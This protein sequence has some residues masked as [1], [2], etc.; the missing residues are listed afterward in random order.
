MGCM[1]KKW[2]KLLGGLGLIL[3]S[4]KYLPLDPWLVLG[5]MFLLIG[6]CGIVCKCDCCGGC[7]M[8]GKKKK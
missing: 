8:P 3:V 4:M 1:C 2:L 7:E 6:L 5:A